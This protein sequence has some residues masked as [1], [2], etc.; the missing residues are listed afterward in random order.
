ML[1]TW[2]MVFANSFSVSISAVVWNINHSPKIISILPSSDPKLIWKNKI[3]NYSIYLIDDE[4]DEISFNITPMTWYS[5][6][7][8]WT[9]VSS[10][11][12]SSSWAYINF[13]Y[14]SPADVPTP[15]PTK[16]TVTLN[17]WPNIIAKDINLYVY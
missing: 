16:V 17:D 12:D 9:I 7:V 2:S 6:P 10:G 1:A 15:N 13:T 4:K 5:N 3:Q 8:S 11:F 14:L